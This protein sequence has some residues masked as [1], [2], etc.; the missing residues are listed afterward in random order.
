MPSDRFDA[1]CDA[2]RIALRRAYAPG[3]TATHMHV[4]ATKLRRGKGYQATLF[5]APDPKLGRLADAKAAVNDKL[6]RFA[7][8][9]AATLFLPRVYADPANS[10]DIC[11]I[12]GKICF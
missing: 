1:L 6:G 8:R 4:M 2:A 12:K 7:V 11:D 10:W 3:L 5:D 9:S